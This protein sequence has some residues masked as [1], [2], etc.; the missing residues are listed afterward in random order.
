MAE[1]VSIINSII[2]VEAKTVK[3]TTD[4]TF[5]V[6]S[7]SLTITLF[8]HS[9]IDKILDR[10]QHF[11]VGILCYSLPHGDTF[12]VRNTQGAMQTLKM[13]SEILM[14]DAKQ[15]LEETRSC[16]HRET[17]ARRGKI[18][19]VDESIEA[20]SRQ[21]QVLKHYKDKEHPTRQVRI[22]QLK[23]MQEEVRANQVA[24]REEIDLQIA[25]EREHYDHHMQAIKAELQA[26]ATDVRRVKGEVI[27]MICHLFRPQ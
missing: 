3:K 8:Q 16:L 17:E 6:L 23:E 4:M 12:Y 24:E 22:D 5:E 7:V 19:Q 1:N 27:C 25:E 21:L 26:R 10:Y 11:K 14:A 9:S 2:S 15:Q 20:T 13:R 18:M